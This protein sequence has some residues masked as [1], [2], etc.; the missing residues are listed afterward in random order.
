MGEVTT[1]VVIVGAGFAGVSAAE[2][3]AKAGVLVTIVDQHPYT[4]FQPL[5][6]Q[7]ATGGLNPGDVTY[8]LRSFVAKQN[9]QVRFRRAKVTDIDRD[10][11]LVHVDD[12]P[13]I[14][15]DYVLV[16]MGVT[17]NFFGIPG[18]DKYAE[19]LYTRTA[20]IEVRDILF[21]AMERL[22]SHP[23][24]AKRGLSVVIV[25]GGPTGVEMAGTIAEMRSVGVP[26]AFPE[27]DPE[28]LR[29]SLVEMTSDLLGPFAPKLRD[30]TR[31]Q[32]KE[33]G[34]NILTDTAIKEVKADSVTLDDDSTMQADMVIWSAGVGGY[35]VL[36]EWGL[37][38]GKGG[39]IKIDAN[40]W[41][42]GEDRILA[43]GDAAVNPDEPL[44]QLAQPAIQGGKHAAEQIIRKAEGKDLKDFSYFDKGTMATIGRAAA[45]VELPQGPKFTGLIAWLMWVVVHLY[46]LLGGR[47]RASAMLNLAVRYLAWPGPTTQIVG[48]LEDT[49]G[50]KEFIAGQT[51]K[52]SEEKDKAEAGSSSN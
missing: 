21:G 20:A 8:S 28:C 52:E 39:R 30:Y 45:V 14:P 5:L 42:H 25:G 37:P 27:L 43:A 34:T 7:V 2:K 22:A 19:T 31:K 41:V 3:L 11:R 4:T 48:D 26:E 51:V 36:E 38:L 46:S 35:S 32:L 47:N 49:H 17:A 24:A 15:Y 1:H 44:P 18:A 16:S 33:R 13:P 6:Y 10:Q 29:V 12:G 50:R 23:E 40:M 9:K